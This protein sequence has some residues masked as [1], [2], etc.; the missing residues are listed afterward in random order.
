VSAT[1][2]EIA[3][4]ARE[5]LALGD[6]AR[7]APDETDRAGYVDWGIACYLGVPVFVGDGVYGTFCF[8]DTK[9][10]EGQFTDWEVTLVDLMSR[11]VDYELNRQQTTDRLKA[12]NEKLEQFA[13][14][15]SHDLRNPLNVIEGA[16]QLAEETG[17]A[18]HFE[19]C[20]RAVDRMDTLIG[21]LLSSARAGAIIEDTE[22]V[23]LASLVEKCWQGVD[24][25]QGTLQLALDTTTV[26]HVDES[27]L[28]QLLENLIRNAFDHGSD[29]TTVTVG[30]LAEGFYVEDDGLGIPTD[31]REKV[32]ES[33]YSTLEGGTGFGLAIVQEIVEAH[34]WRVRVHDA[35]AGGARFE[36]TGIK[37]V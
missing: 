30:R 35:E 5:T 21:D 20:H 7:D 29:D 8:Y 19:R 12:Q 2:C 6:V 36:I 27:R 13:S 24:L 26:I 3:A 9:P 11:W 17:E 37:D 33:G 31:D 32:F 15:V 14:H 34:G 16:I 4:S 18:E 22:R 23:P 28:T 25:R 1:N 10:R